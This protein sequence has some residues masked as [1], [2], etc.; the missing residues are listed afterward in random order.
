MSAKRKQTSSVRGEDF[1]F[2]AYEKQTQKIKA[3]L[4][5][6]PEN[7]PKLQRK[8]REICRDCGTPVVS[9]ELSCNR[10]GRIFD[11][12]NP[13]TVDM[14]TRRMPPPRLPERSS[15][16][17]EDQMLRP[18]Y[19]SDPRRV[20][21]DSRADHRMP[22][23]DYAPPRTTPSQYPGEV[24]RGSQR[25]YDEVETTSKKA[26]RKSKKLENEKYEKK[27]KRDRREASSGSSGE[28]E[29][30]SDED[31]EILKIQRVKAKNLPKA[32]A[33]KEEEKRS[34][35]NTTKSE[36]AEASKKKKSRRHK[37][38]IVNNSESG[39]ES[40]NDD[41]KTAVYQLVRKRS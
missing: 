7:S 23:Y 31:E 21:F 18:L 10:C 6:E 33:S 22:Q 36:E 25:Q 2:Y 38:K 32:K 29:S 14:N 5:R 17:A 20:S 41:D 34:S 35:K 28:S 39:E 40:D 16:Y 3:H 12:R 11:R 13:A 1:F 30:S 9:G 27:K 15:R 19:S 26:K 24:H 4:R 8:M 37:I